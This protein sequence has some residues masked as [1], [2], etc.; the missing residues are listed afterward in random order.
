MSA[1]IDQGKVENFDPKLISEIQAMIWEWQDSGELPSD[2]A[3]RI[4][5][6]IAGKGLPK[7]KPEC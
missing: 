3:L 7:D 2:L 1:T 6:H 5:K 4:I